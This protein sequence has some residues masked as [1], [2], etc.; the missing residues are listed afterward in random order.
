MRKNGYFVKSVVVLGLVGTLAMAG[1]IE[2]ND[3]NGQDVVIKSS[4]QISDNENE[5]NE[6]KMAKIGAQ[7]VISI[8]KSKYPGKVIG[9]RLSNEN[10]NL[11][12]IAELFK[13]NQ[14]TNIMLDAG[15]GKILAVKTDKNDVGQNDDSEG[16][17]NEGND[18]GENEKNSD[19]PWYKF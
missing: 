14:I 11:V 6:N 17:D 1:D 18:N 9:V 13:H 15:N 8:V 5:T 2:T 4:V 7:K 16:N 12:Y 3:D 19:E 10:G